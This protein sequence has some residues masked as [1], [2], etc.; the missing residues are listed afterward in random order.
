VRKIVQKVTP[1]SHDPP[2][3]FSIPILEHVKLWFGASFLLRLAFRS[4]LSLGEI[5]ASPENPAGI[6][7]D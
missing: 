6:Q 7:T 3:H 1:G 2:S 4:L 5:P